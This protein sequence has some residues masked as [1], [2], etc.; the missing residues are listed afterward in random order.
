[1]KANAEQVALIMALYRKDHLSHH[2]IKGQ[3]WGVRRTRAALSR[4][5]RREGRSQASP[6]AARAKALSKKKRS[7]LTND[8]LKFLNERQNLE[9]NNRRLNPTVVERGHNRTKAIL[10][11]AGTAAAAERFFNSPTGK[12]AIEAGK[13]AVANVLLK[14]SVRLIPRGGLIP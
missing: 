7:Q 12:L 4:A 6:E 9:S 13:N 3:R 8:E 10:A 2:G 5:A 1:M 11:L 14:D